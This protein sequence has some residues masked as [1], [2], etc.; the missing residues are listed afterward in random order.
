M[1]NIVF[2]GTS[3]TWGEGLHYY[4][5]LPNINIDSIVYDK[6]DYTFEHIN[7]IKNN[8]F[9]RLVS[10][11]FNTK[12]LVRNENGG[13]NDVVL[14]FVNN[15]LNFD[16]CEFIIFQFTEPFR[17]LIEF[18]YKGE[19]RIVNIKLKNE[20]IETEFEKYI[21]EKW[22]FNLNQFIDYYLSKKVFNLQ[23]LIEKI[24]NKGIKR[25]FILN[26]KTHF[27][28]YFVQNDFYSERIIKI[29]I[30][31]FIFD[32]IEDGLFGKR[33]IFGLQKGT[34]LQLIKDDQTLFEKFGK[35]IENRHLTLE[36]H[37]IIAENIINKIQ[38]YI[39]EYEN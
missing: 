22:N 19:K 30:D 20:V 12:D 26:E 25:C 32:T 10:N 34:K 39:Y 3:I 33:G 21:A 18:N 27:H 29:K 11:Y 38:N 24:E 8:R 9:S 28:K 6:N 2:A 31:N 17:D 13:T 35:N 16:E 4:S 1:K 14:N 23:K 37:K 7:F 15:E 36:S 5:D